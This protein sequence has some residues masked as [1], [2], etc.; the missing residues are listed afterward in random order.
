MRGGA[1]SGPWPL[2]STAPAEEKGSSVLS[3]Y[4][5]RDG[6]LLAIQNHLG[7]PR[8]V[9]ISPADARVEVLESKNPLLN[10][11]C[12]GVAAGDEFYFMANR[13]N[14]PAERVVLRSRCEGAARSRGVNSLPARPEPR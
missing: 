4:D 11:P 1:G 6:R 13:S 12:T 10:V 9:R 14:Q 3:V 7:G 2:S 8:V 5:L